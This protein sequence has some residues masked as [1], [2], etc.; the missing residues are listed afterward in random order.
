MGTP[1][2]NG[3]EKRWFEFFF[4]HVFF[5]LV[6][7]LIVVSFYPAREKFEIGSDEGINLMKAMLVQR[8]YSLYGDIWS[9][10][11]PLFTHLLSA[12]MRTFGNMI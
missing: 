10:Q 5:P 4:T 2:T 9:D 7:V 11:P 12:V 6:F 3:R 8:G 1:I